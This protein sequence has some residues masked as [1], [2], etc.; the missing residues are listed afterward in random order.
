[1]PRFKKDWNEELVEIDKFN[2]LDYQ[3]EVIQ[4]KQSIVLK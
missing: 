3:Q 2:Q 1:M 4:E